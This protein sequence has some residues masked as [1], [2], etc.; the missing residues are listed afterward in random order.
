MTPPKINEV[1][2]DNVRHRLLDLVAATCEAQPTMRVMLSSREPTYQRW[3]SGFTHARLGPF[4]QA[5]ISQWSSLYLTP[6]LEP[7]RWRVF[8]NHLSDEPDVAGL[9][10]NPLLLSIVAYMYA[11]EHVV[12]EN[13][14]LILER[15]LSAL[16]KDWDAVRGVVRWVES[17]AMSRQMRSAL[18]DMSF[19]AASNSRDHFVIDDLTR[20]AERLVGFRS[21]PIAILNACTSAGVI[22]E[23]AER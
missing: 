11:R 3:M 16:L 19:T 22:Q 23:T 18:M 13:K 6:R 2:H 15:C 21:E 20:R 4:D 7:N 12:P 9:V 10:R 14:A 1:T 8:L 5:Q 17:P